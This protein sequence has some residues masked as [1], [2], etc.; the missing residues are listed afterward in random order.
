MPFKKKEKLGEANS[1]GPINLLHYRATVMLLMAFCLL[2]TS[3]ELIAGMLIYPY[4]VWKLTICLSSSRYM[5]L[6]YK[7]FSR[8]SMLK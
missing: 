8:V 6:V 1:E 4:Q 3:T 7:S 5:F 2:V